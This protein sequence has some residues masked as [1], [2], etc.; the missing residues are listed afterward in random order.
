MWIPVESLSS[1]SDLRMCGGLVFH[2]G[3]LS[4]SR[5]TIMVRR[6]ALALQQPLKGNGNEEYLKTGVGWG[7]GFS[8]Q[9]G[10]WRS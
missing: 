10:R 2:V 8:R 3:K 6:G 7:G 5:L 9:D 4:E 1:P